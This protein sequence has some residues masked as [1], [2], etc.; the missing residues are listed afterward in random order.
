MDELI[1]PA[2]LAGLVL[3]L[4][5]K[6]AAPGA[7]VRPLSGKTVA[8]EAARCPSIDIRFPPRRLLGTQTISGELKKGDW[9]RAQMDGTLSENANG[10]VAAPFFTLST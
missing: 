1:Y 7:A 8:H 2:V 9:L 4:A 5:D 6:G 3:G 10:E